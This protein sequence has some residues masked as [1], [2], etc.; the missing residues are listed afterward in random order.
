MTQTMDREVSLMCNL[1]QSVE[2]RGIEK[3][4]TQGILTSLQNLMVSMGLNIEEAMNALLIPD[5]ERPSYLR[6]MKQ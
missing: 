4:I 6:M 2:A 5:A 3:G 1:S